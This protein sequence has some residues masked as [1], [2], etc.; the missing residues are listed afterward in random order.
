MSEE[1]P[2]VLKTSLSYKSSGNVGSGLRDNSSTN[3]VTSPGY[4]R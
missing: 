4:H 2:G 1:P 3:S